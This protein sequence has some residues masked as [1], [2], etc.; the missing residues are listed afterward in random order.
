[1]STTQSSMISI[2]VNN[3]E[4]ENFKLLSILENRPVSQM[5]KDLVE[6]ELK[7]KKLSSVD[8]RKLS[9][10]AR[11]ALLLKLSE[12]AIPIYNK[13]KDELTVDET[14]DGIV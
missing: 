8:I 11:N 5:V 14:G 6:R 4:K 7:S 10:E 3:L 9:K 13:Y 2:R 12:E 1:M